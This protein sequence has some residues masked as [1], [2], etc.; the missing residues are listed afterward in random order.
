MLFYRQFVFQ[1]IAV[2]CFF[3]VPFLSDVWLLLLKVPLAKSSVRLTVVITHTHTFMFFPSFFPSYVFFLRL[4]FVFLFFFLLTFFR[5]CCSCIY[6]PSTH[7]SLIFIKL[8]LFI[9]SQIA[10]VILFLFCVYRYSHNLWALVFDE[11]QEFTIEPYTTIKCAQHFNSWLQ[12][13]ADVKTQQQSS[14]ECKFSEPESTRAQIPSWS[15]IW[16][17]S[18]SQ[19]LL[20]KHIFSSQISLFAKLNS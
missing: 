1:I 2:T 9:L 6:L 3:C 12:K 7:I 11:S 4:F 17:G 16:Y 20:P 13:C 18:L 8:F 5:P 14:L 10:N 19:F 15:T